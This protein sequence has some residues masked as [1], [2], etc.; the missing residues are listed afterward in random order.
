MGDRPSTCGSDRLRACVG[1]VSVSAVDH[2]TGAMLCE[3]C[4][5]SRPNTP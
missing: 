3:Q 1:R 2:H 4:R 5:D